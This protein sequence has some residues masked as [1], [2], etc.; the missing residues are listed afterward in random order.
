MAL[1]SVRGGQNGKGGKKTHPVLSGK[2]TKNKQIEAMGSV[3]K[4]T[5]L[6]LRVSFIAALCS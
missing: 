1:S 3:W 6:R 4:V 5:T 2:V